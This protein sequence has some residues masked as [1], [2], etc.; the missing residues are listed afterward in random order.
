MKRTFW[1]LIP[2]LLL[3]VLSGG[4]QS[5]PAAQDSH[6]HGGHLPRAKACA[7]VHEFVCL[8]LSPL[9]NLV[10]EGH[11]DHAKTMTLCND[12]RRSARRRRSSRPATARLPASFATPVRRPATN[13]RLPAAA[14]S[15]TT[16]TW[17]SAKSCRECAAACR[18]MIH[19]T[20]G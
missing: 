10:T 9:R 16:S 5:T 20:S 7:G 12:C 15:P 11:K 18:E 2:I 3:A 4:N 6:E 17:P 14:R 1:S 13:A 19:H 8:V